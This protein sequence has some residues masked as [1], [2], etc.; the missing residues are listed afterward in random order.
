MKAY[1]SPLVKE[2][3]SSEP[4]II[5]NA[6]KNRSYTFIYKGKVYDLVQVGLEPPKPKKEE[7]NLTW[8]Q[9]FKKWLNYFLK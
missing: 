4:H 8:K 6:I 1:L 9:E 7:V 3:L 5:M 2:I